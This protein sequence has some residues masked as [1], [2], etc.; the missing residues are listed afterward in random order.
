MAC[1]IGRRTTKGMDKSRRQEMAET[2]SGDDG[3]GGRSWQRWTLTAV[4]DDDRNGGRRQR[5]TTKAVDDDGM[6]DWV[7]DYEGE[8]GECAANNNSKTKG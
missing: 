4:D 8:G 2:W 6:Q 3:C 7:A 1:K 5:W